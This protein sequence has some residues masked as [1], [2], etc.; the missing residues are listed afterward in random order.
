MSDQTI[1][2]GLKIKDN[3]LMFKDVIIYEF[4]NNNISD[5]YKIK[6]SIYDLKKYLSN[7]LKNY[8]TG[9]YAW[10]VYKNNALITLD[11]YCNMDGSDRKEKIEFISFFQNEIIYL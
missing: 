2:K 7:H 1:Y 11:L 6:K 9:A 4:L 8:I 3:K 10:Q 5:E